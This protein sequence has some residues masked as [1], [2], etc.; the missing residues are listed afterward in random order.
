MGGMVPVDLRPRN[1]VNLSG[2]F[3]EER[4]KSRNEFLNIYISQLRDLSINGNLKRTKISS[5]GIL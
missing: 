1:D 4:N 5:L 2:V 3:Y